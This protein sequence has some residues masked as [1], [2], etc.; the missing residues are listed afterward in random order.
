MART[1]LPQ[2]RN[3]TEPTPAYVLRGAGLF[4]IYRDELVYLGSGRWFIPSGSGQG[5]GY[6]ARP[7]RRPE[8]ECQGFSSHKH[9]SHV[10]CAEIATRKSAVCDECGERCWWP[11]LRVVEESDE[12]LSWYPGD[13]LCRECVGA[14]AWSCLPRCGHS[15]RGWC[16]PSPFVFCTLRGLIRRGDY[17]YHLAN[18]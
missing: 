13:V 4:E 11:Q 16:S 6:I 17:A 7:G 3:T 2:S 14:G 10:A 5:K 12:L 8:C 15:V 18:T 1:S 9:C